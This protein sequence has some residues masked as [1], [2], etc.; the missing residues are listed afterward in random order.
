[1]DRRQVIKLA[2][3]GVATQLL[4]PWNVG[5][6]QDR[7]GNA[8]TR[9][10]PEIDPRH[11]L[12]PVLNMAYEAR[13]AVEAVKDYTATFIKQE[14]IDKRVR[15]T[16]MN[17]KLREEP[18]SVY[19]YFVDPYKGREVIYIDGKNKN[20]LQ[21]HETG[22][23]SVVGTVS[24]APTSPDAMNGNKYPVTMIGLRT[25]LERV[26]EQWENEAQFGEVEPKYYPEAKL[27]DLPCRCIESKHPQP[28]NQFKSHMT[29]LYLHGESGL[30]VRVE[31]YAWP[32]GKDQPP[33][34]FEEYSYMNLK[35]NVGL[36]DADF[37]TRNPNY[38]FAK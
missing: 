23:L 22:L 9:P 28:R 29:R 30:P 3:A 17:L 18:F 33:Q 8:G 27:G 38:A 36:Q 26:I 10:K 12:V 7:T 15:K 21:V 20:Q 2:A 4:T 34:L 32:A 19:L 16:V 5:F 1:M 11:P 31:Q 14:L 25:M 37:D 24:L 35:T 13:K 6:A